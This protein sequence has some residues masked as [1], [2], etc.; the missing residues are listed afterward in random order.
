[1]SEAWRSDDAV[2]TAH[3]TLLFCYQDALERE[4]AGLPP[5][6][7]PPPRAGGMGPT[8]KVKAEESQLVTAKDVLQLVTDKQD[9]MMAELSEVKRLLL[10]RD[11]ELQALHHEVGTLLRGGDW[12]TLSTVSAGLRS[13]DFGTPW[14]QAS[15]ATTRQDAFVERPSP[16]PEQRSPAANI[17]VEGWRSRASWTPT[18]ADRVENSI[19]SQ[20]SLA[21]SP[22]TGPGNRDPAAEVWESYKVG[23]GHVSTCQ[24]LPGEHGGGGFSV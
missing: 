21:R 12:H 6:A 2:G 14:P 5:K 16:I 18:V 17:S 19:A 9:R 11:A 1:M 4:K 22:D 8:L 15:P 7:L 10:R 20:T 23:L 3:A 24:K 13:M